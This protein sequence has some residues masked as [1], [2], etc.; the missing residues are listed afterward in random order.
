MNDELNTR[1]P[2]QP[3]SAAPPDASRDAYEGCREDLLD[4]K[5]RALVAEENNRQLTRALQAEVNSPT[6]MGEAAA[7]TVV[8]PAGK[9]HQD[10]YFTWNR[11]A[12]KDYV[13]DKRLPCDFYLAPLPAR[14]P[15]TPLTDE[16]AEALIESSD[17]RWHED[18]FRIDSRDL[19]ALLRK[20]HGIAASEGGA[21]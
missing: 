3:E 7:P 21:T 14:P 5:H 13:L 12:G 10:G 15:R 16:Q 11:R 17:G 2:V 6:F 20:A 18:E 1:A 8:E 19:M 4:W 9:L